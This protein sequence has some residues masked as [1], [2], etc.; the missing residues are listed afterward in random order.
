MFCVAVTQ[1]VCAC[2]CVSLPVAPRFNEFLQ[3]ASIAQ[4]VSL[5]EQ[6]QLGGIATEVKLL[7]VPPAGVSGQ[8]D[9][10]SQ[11]QSVFV[12]T[13]LVGCQHSGKFLKLPRW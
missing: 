1:D 7:H 3:P 6:V 9:G 8:G 10:S 5:A 12:H 13:G 2:A 11:V 4:P